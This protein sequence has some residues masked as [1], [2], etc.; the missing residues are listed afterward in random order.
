MGLTTE[1]EG[2]G[3]IEKN[4]LLALDTAGRVTAVIL[5]LQE[6]DTTAG[7]VQANDPPLLFAAESA[8]VTQ[9]LPLFVVY[10]IFTF[11][12]MLSE[13]Q[14]MLLVVLEFHASP[15]LGAAI[16]IVGAMSVNSDALTSVGWPVTTPV[17]LTEQWIDGVTVSGMFQIYFPAPFKTVPMFRQATALVVYS[18]L[19]LSNVPVDVQV[20]CIGVPVNQ[21]ILSL[22]KVKVTVGV[23]PETISKYAWLESLGAPPVT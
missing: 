8:M 7:N 12:I 2:A 3:I 1:I 21:V 19:T 15:P 9:T 10:S 22:G 17:I 16:L 5:T 13:P 18:I 14:V 4:L 20:T 23:A 11:P 6:S